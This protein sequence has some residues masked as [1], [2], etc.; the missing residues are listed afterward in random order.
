[1]R[2]AH[3]VIALFAITAAACG[4]KPGKSICDNQ[5]PPPAACMTM[6]DP[7]PGAPNSCPGGY[8][9]AADG[10]CD[11]LCTPSGGECGDGYV[12]TP[13]G[14]CKGENE[15]EGLECDVAKCTSQG[16]PETTLSGTVF[17][18][19]GTLPLYGIKVY[20]PNAPVPAFTEG[21]ECSRCVNDDQMPGSPVNGIVATTDEAGKFTLTG[22]P[23]GSNIPL[24]ITSGKWRRQIV[25]PSI[26]DCADTA[27]ST[28]DSRLPKNKSEGDIPKIALTTGSADSLECLLRRMGID[29]S[30]IHTGPSGSGRIHLYA[31]NGPASF[32]GGFPGGSG[33]IT[34]ASNMWDDVNKLKAYDIVILSC[35][36]SQRPDT[37]LQGGLNA[38]R[39]YANLG[40]RVFASHW[41]NIWIGGNFT[42]GGQPAVAEWVP[43]A[44][45]ANAGDPGAG[46][47]DVIDENSNPKGSSFATWMINVMGSTV[48]GE[49]PIQDG[50][51]KTT[52]S[53]VNMGMAERWT[54]LKGTTRPQNFQFTTPTTVQAAERCGKV[55]FSDMHVSGNGSTTAYPGGCGD[56]TPRALTPQEKALA[57]MLFDLASCVS[58]IL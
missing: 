8:H 20:V 18:P 57:F 47:I 1:M 4:G 50:T 40:G 44:T 35:E 53:G 19:N 49:I 56:P 52:A 54:F 24:V 41:H 27:V 11:A 33:A 13:D 36:G 22:V 28:T 39:D 10:Y 37:K 3:L 25:V 45:W 29:D 23:S 46:T 9:C 17:A 16:K 43:L 30:E 31:G 14:R 5:V 21:A 42:G 55:V 15:C 12:C 2:V 26:S 58:V 32:Q 48:R 6:C 34:N 51:A 7:S 38:M